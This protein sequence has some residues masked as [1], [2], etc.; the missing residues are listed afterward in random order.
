MWNMPAELEHLRTRVTAAEARLDA[1]GS[2]RAMVDMDQAAI[3]IRL[4]AQERLVRALALTQRDHS[5]QLSWL[6]GRLERI[7]G[8]PGRGRGRHALSQ[9]GRCH[10]RPWRPRALVAAL[11]GV[12]RWA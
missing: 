9:C 1:E 8:G 6:G 7:Q 2:L 11:A 5:A 10:V 4:D 3:T 12:A